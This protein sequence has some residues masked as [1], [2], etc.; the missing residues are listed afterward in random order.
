MVTI[1]IPLQNVENLQYLTQQIST[2]GSSLYHH[3]LT[4]QEV[5]SY[6]PVSQYQAALAYLSSKGLKVVYSSLDSIIVAEGT[7]SQVSQSL[8]LSY[9]VYTD[10]SSSYYTS[11]GVSPISGAYVYSTNV[12]AVL[13]HT[14]PD[15]VSS[16]SVPTV[17]Q[18]AAAPTNQT[19]PDEGYP[20]TDLPSVY[21]ATAL[22]AAGDKGAGY[23]VGILDFYGDPYMAQQLQFFDEVYGL[24]SSPFTVTPIGPYN[25]SLGVT[26]G[27]DDE[28]SLDVESVHAMAPEAGIDLYIGNGA[29]PISAAIAPIVQQDKVNDVTQSFGYSE[30][31]LSEF[32]A[33]GLE[34][35]VILA[36]Q[37]Y[38]LGSAEGITFIAS[39]GD[40]GGSGFSGGPEGNPGYPST[41]PYN[42]AVGGTT[43]YITFDGSH[44]SSALQT[45]WSSY[46]F[47]PYQQNYGG[48]TGGVSVLEPVPWYQAG[49]PVPPTFS[50]GRLTPDVSL[51]AAVFPAVQVILPGNLSGLYGGTS[52]SNQ[53]FGGLLTLL[54]GST[55]S[56]FGLLNPTL[57]Q[58]GR[59][60]SV[61]AKVYTPITYGYTIPWV[62][63]AGY[64]LVTGFGAPNI[65]EMARFI[66]S[67]GSSPLAVNVT[68]SVGSTPPVDVLPG[69]SISVSAT[70]THGKGAVTTGKFSAYL[71]T[72]AGTVASSALSYQGSSG[73]W[74]G[75]LT[76]P[77]DASGISY[78]TVN[79]T[80]NGA[81]GGGFVET[82]A[83]YLA[84]FLSP[85][86]D[87]PYSTV[88]GVPIQMNVT[89][90]SGSPVSGAFS[91]TASTYS[92]KSNT[93]KQVGS[94]LTA[95][96]NGLYVGSLDGNFPNG[97]MTL[98][99]AG[100]LY[101]FLPFINGVSLQ[102]S[103]IEPSVLAQPG[104][105]G[106][107]QAL[108]ILAQ[109]QAP[110]NTPA[111]TSS[112]TNYPV[113]F[114][115][116][117]GSNVTAALVSPS[118][119]VVT[120]GTLFLNTYLSSLQAIQGWLTVPSGLSP[121]VYDVMLNSSYS[122]PDLG[123]WI[124]G[125]YFGQVY[126]SPSLSTITTTL[127]A[128]T[129]YE[130][131]SVAVNAKIDYAN[132]TAVK[133]GMYSATVY[134]SNLK[135]IYN[136]FYQY[137]NV[138]LWYDS[139]TGLWTGNAQLPSAY[140]SG[141]SLPVDLGALYL[142]GPYDVFVSGLSADG[143]PAN[144]DISTQY[145]FQIQ[146]YLYLNDTTFSSPPQSSN[147]AFVRD[148]IGGT[149]GAP[150]VLSND[151]FIGVNNLQGPVTITGS[152]IQ[153]TLNLHDANATLIGVTGGAIVAT[154]SDLTIEQ[155]S[156]GSLD[157]VG[158][159]VAMNG[160]EVTTISPPV[161]SVS[162]QAPSTGGI[163]SGSS[164]SFVVNGSDIS[165][166]AVYVDGGLV[167]TFTP[168]AS[169]T[170]PLDGASM[171]VGVH[172][173]K[174]VV[175][176]TD[177][178]STSSMVY[179]S[180]DGPLVA[181][182]ASIGTLSTQ[183][184]SQSSRIG[185]LSSQL[186]NADEL[187]YALA[188]VAVLALIIAIVAVARGRPRPTSSSSYQVQEAPPP[189]PAPGPSPESSSSTPPEPFL[190]PSASPPP[191][192]D[193]ETQPSGGC[194]I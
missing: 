117:E 101:G 161:P 10:G 91:L 59:S 192:P 76:V 58:M 6:L 56:T 139:A 9:E 102:N 151:L 16:K 19:L 110:L 77:A 36:D 164:G 92:I 68:A 169:Y 119:K 47:V 150:E 182:S 43:T 111:V 175:T 113:S 159:H 65:G 123:T 114:N 30:S 149:S 178:I 83:G 141:G 174:V 32:G 121:G 131:Q 118:G 120:S 137:V 154:N 100:P 145:Q 158:S 173:F 148:T 98:W 180:T 179:F 188:V 49:I 140:N 63:T 104:A 171:A 67:A 41:S 18:V 81:S 20:L 160:S 37:Y 96:S 181:Q 29:L 53:L 125:S 109:L 133:Y 126:V 167:Q 115:V 187:S 72:L 17:G 89:T 138:D 24:P 7:A 107:G 86:F 5:Q 23:T 27:W 45:A 135:T 14:P 128:S 87:A 103:Y 184:S 69:Q 183:V 136:A 15:L 50:S 163:Y 191:P 93:Y 186:S 60:S 116:D 80:S 26:F 162:I 155:S 34:L 61:S 157:L 38:M 64:N 28:I 73:S 124:N 194:S 153:G 99:G 190:E 88:F 147:V 143:V 55:K 82:F 48:S 97:P 71:D 13:L 127:S 66:D 70:I 46:G 193:E 130:G 185:S 84:T 142:D 146:P 168:A 170:V 106:P 52:E 177:G 134:P 75:T 166:V 35:N 31:M 4:S 95:K 189:P 165:S 39:T 57:Y 51:N 8:G 3:F 12:T 79:G 152:Q 176:Q 172:T 40:S 25:P 144:T 112:E 105:V 156:L 1:G 21:N 33:T 132:G 94:L 54:M 44:P 11:S 2:P 62:A 90:I 74:T 78:I 108:Y 122:S 22:F 42:V 85:T 129:V